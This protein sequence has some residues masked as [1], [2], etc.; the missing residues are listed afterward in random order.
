VHGFRRLSIARQLKLESVPV[1]IISPEFCLENLYM[2]AIEENFLSGVASLPE[3][4]RILRHTKRFSH[5]NRNTWLRL[6]ELPQD[7]RK[8]RRL[9]KILDFSDTWQQ[10]LAE[11]QIP[12]RRALNILR[13]SALET[14]TPLICRSISLSQMEQL[15]GMLQEIATRENIQPETLF[16]NYKLSVLLESGISL[17]D[18]FAYVK[19]IRYPRLSSVHEKQEKIIQKMKAPEIV[20]ILLD[21]SLER[22]EMKLSF[23]L[24]NDSQLEQSIQ[25]LKTNKDML[26]LLLQRDWNDEK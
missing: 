9:D 22:E 21:P 20:K 3:K 16:Y 23:T 18:F 14:L 11:K 7:E 24:R 13:F 1:R 26:N 17:A 19:K 8:L 2:S 15:C 5:K 25:W 12:V 4:V 6:L 10:W